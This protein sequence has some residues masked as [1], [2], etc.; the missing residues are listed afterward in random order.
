MKTLS[1][2]FCVFDI[3]PGTSGR[4]DDFGEFM[5]LGKLEFLKFFSKIFHALGGIK[6]HI[7]YSLFVFVFRILLVEDAI[8]FTAQIY[9]TDA[10]RA[11]AA[12]KQKIT[13]PTIIHALA[14]K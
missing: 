1:A 5:R 9:T 7:R 8:F 14:V 12:V 13:V 6:P 4:I 3:S 10:I 11:I 2:V